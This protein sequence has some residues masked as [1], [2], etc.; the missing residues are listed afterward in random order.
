MFGAERIHQHLQIEIILIVWISSIVMLCRWTSSH[1]R[2]HL[3]GPAATMREYG[4]RRHSFASR[5]PPNQSR[6]RCLA[7][8]CFQVYAGSI[9]ILAIISRFY[10]SIR[11]ARVLDHV[12]C[13]QLRIF[14]Q[15]CSAR[16]IAGISQ[17][18]AVATMQPFSTFRSSSIDEHN[19]L[20]R[21]FALPSNRWPR[22]RPMSNFETDFC[23]GW[24]IPSGYALPADCV[25]EDSKTKGG[26]WNSNNPNM[27][28]TANATRLEFLLCSLCPLWNSDEILNSIEFLDS[29]IGG[30]I[31]YYGVKNFVF[32]PTEQNTRPFSISCS[33][34]IRL[35]SNSDLWPATM[36][37]NHD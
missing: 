17:L 4:M 27:V 22:T 1:M 2:T 8:L 35:W 9:F 19:A 36:N 15:L 11:R 10:V 20:I 7:N 18:V 34:H 28:G 32:R 6:F 23:R 30:C 21:P 5:S 31:V 24:V 14:V 25:R 16:K 3:Q 12:D 29:K 13:K 37:S 33:S 26:K